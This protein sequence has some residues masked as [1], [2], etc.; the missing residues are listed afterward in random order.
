M[1]IYQ[2]ISA[3]TRIH[4]QTASRRQKNDQWVDMPRAY[5]APVTAWRRFKNWQEKGVWNEIVRLLRDKVY[6]EGKLS[7]EMVSIDSKTV[8]AKKGANA[9]D[10]TGIKRR[11]ARRSTLRSVARVYR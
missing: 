3:T 10:T 1:G 11:K 4:W 6:A 9:S 8:T 5:G 7:L 2:T